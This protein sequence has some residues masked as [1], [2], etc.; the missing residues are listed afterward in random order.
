[1][2]RERFL[3]SLTELPNHFEVQCGSWAAFKMCR[4]LISFT[5]DAKYGD[6]IERLVYNGIGADIS[7]SPDGR[8]F[9]YAHYHLGG[10]KKVL[11]PDGWACCTGSRPMAVAAY[12]DLIYFK[13]ERGIYVNLYMPSVVKWNN[14]MLRQ[15]TRFPE[16]SHV[17]F[18][19]SAD[20]PVRFSIKLRVPDWL[21]EP[22]EVS[23][24]G[25]RIHT[26][27][28]PAHWM[29]IERE[30]KDGDK[31]HVTL[32]LAF[33]L[34]HLNGEG[35]GFPAA[36]MYG[37]IAMAFRSADGSPASRIDFNNL[38]HSLVPSPSEPLTYHLDSNPDVLVRT[39]YAF[40][41]GEPYFLYLDPTASN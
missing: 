13:D 41:E 7:M 29:A 16:S 4:Y 11:Y 5:G 3:T 23:V 40:K 8:V 2:P 35:G 14:V 34:S 10:A 26:K 22:M 20:E 32:P 24:N 15:S 18:T 1:M 17:E 31:L 12:H 37:P 33:W 21:Q 9:Y 25:A 28:D 39:F 6:W 30:W 27:V 36:V 38:E 19:V